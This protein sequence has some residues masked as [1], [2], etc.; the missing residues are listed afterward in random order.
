M[1]FKQLKG[2]FTT[3]PLLVAV[4]NR[5]TRTFLFYFYFLFLE[6]TYIIRDVT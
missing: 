4:M 5:D 1:A 3:K 6:W 2:I